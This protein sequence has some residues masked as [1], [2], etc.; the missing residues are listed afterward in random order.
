MA[1]LTWPRLTH[2]PGTRRRRVVNTHTDPKFVNRVEGNLA[3]KRHRS[4]ENVG[5]SGKIPKHKEEA[6]KASKSKAAAAAS[7]VAKRHLIVARI[8]IRRI[9]AKQMESG[10]D[11]AARCH[12]C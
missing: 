2:A 4:A 9:V 8:G 3:T 10:G 12:V 11:E 5:T 1:S 7:E 6:S